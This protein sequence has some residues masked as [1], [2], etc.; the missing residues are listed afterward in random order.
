M[1]VKVPV[2]DNRWDAG[3]NGCFVVVKNRYL[4]CRTH[5][6]TELQGSSETRRMN[7]PRR[8]SEVGSFSISA[9][10]QAENLACRHRINSL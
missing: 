1:V 5:Y 2:D 4:L 7:W 9:S 10:V 8:V 6:P 3:L